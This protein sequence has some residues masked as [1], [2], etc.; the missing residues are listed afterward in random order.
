MAKV[1]VIL[2]KGE[3]MWPKLSKPDTIGEYA[4]GKYKTKVRVKKTDAAEVCAKIKATA[5]ALGVS[6]LPWADDKEDGECIVFTAKSKFQPVIF[7]SDGKT[8]INPVKAPEIGGGSTIR[9]MAE[10]FPYKTGV[11]LQM[12]Q[13]QVI[14][15][16]EWG[17]TS[18]FDAEE[19]SFDGSEY[20]GA[21]A[22]EEGQGFA[23][24]G[25]DD[26]DF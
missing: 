24:E 12:K 26:A 19:G 23:N 6:K 4:D 21:E 7:A 14:D 11:S 18:A 5:D 13:V 20:S 15:L 8:K 9:V 2:P 25:A 10:L 16:V 22:S 17:G 3:A 1:H